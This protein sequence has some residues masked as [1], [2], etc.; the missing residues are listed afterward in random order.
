MSNLNVS[1]LNILAIEHSHS[2]LIHMT[3]RIKIIKN[4]PFNSTFNLRKTRKIIDNP[5]IKKA[6]QNSDILTQIIKLNKDT[7][8]FMPENFSSCIDKGDVKY[9]D[10]VPVNKKK[11]QTN[12]TSYSPVSILSKLFQVL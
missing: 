8:P 6:C 4:R 1:N 12:K 7:A 9:A 3:N 5:N 11:S 10:T 2:N